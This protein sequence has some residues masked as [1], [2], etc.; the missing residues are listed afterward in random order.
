MSCI[1]SEVGNALLKTSKKQ[2]A[3]KSMHKKTA[4]EV[5]EIENL[6]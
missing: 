2:N 4:S 3:R 1:G 6:S 5:K